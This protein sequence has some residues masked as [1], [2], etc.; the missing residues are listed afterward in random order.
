M[1]RVGRGKVSRWADRPRCP[2]M[3]SEKGRVE[4]LLKKTEL[5]IGKHSKH[6][7]GKKTNITGRSGK[8]I[9]AT[10]AQKN[11]HYITRQTLHLTN[12]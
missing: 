11:E 12:I 1:K 4:L 10:F 5:Y 9:V 7:I 2:G 8:G 3:G 6:Y